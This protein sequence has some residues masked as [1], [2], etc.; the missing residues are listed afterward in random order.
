VPPLATATAATA[1]TASEQPADSTDIRSKGSAGLG[2]RCENLSL[3]L[4]TALGTKPGQGILVLAVTTGSSADRAGIRPGD[5]ISFAGGEPVVDVD[6]LDRIIK[7]ANSPL[8]IVT[9]RKGTTRVVAAEF[10][11]PP[12]P[13]AKA[14]GAQTT[15]QALESLRGEVKSLREEVQKLRAELASQAKGSAV[16]HP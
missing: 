11:M 4:A 7:T 1:P 5:V 10:P 14:S 16:P 8:P 9:V 2:V 15:E 13:E 12:P 3:D 6:G